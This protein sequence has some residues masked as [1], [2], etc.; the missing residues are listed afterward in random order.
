[1]RLFVL[2]VKA[3][4]LRKILHVPFS[5]LSQFIFTLLPLLEQILILLYGLIKILFLFLG[6]QVSFLD[7][8]LL[9]VKLC[10]QVAVLVPAF[11]VYHS[12]LINLSS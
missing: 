10:L 4:Y 7:S 2:L 5:D 1:M 3:F 9:S 6:F 11:I 12:L 8:L